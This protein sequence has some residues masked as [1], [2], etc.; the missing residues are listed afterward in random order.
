MIDAGLPRATASD[1]QVVGVA[2][3]TTMGEAQV[4]E[5]IDE[6]FV[7]GGLT[8]VSADLVTRY[9]CHSIATHVAADVEAT[10]PVI[11]L[12]TA[13][14]AGNYAIGYAFDA[15]RRG[16]ATVM[17]AGGADAFSRI[18]V[19]GFARLSATAPEMCQPFDRGR[20]GMVVGEGA[21]VLVLEPLSRR[22]PR[23]PCA[24]RSRWPRVR[25]FP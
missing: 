16:R 19:A 22:G 25:A 15:L 3:G 11:M 8:S 20:K 2:M 17:L 5:A 13:C 12:P 7:G 21:A 10:G 18:S 23:R 14:A 4:L 1:D 6:E 24:S 9:P